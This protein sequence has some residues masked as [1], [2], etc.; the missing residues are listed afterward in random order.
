[1][2][3][4]FDPHP[5]SILYPLSAEVGIIDGCFCFS[6]LFPPLGSVA[7]FSSQCF[8]VCTSQDES[9]VLQLP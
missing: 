3:L 2:A 9:M 5:F 7:C 1:M 8:R 6:T 4:D